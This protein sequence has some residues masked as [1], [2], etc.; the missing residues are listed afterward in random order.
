MLKYKKDAK[1]IEELIKACIGQV[2]IDDDLICK[3][4]VCVYPT[5][6][7]EHWVYPLSLRCSKRQ[8]G[9]VCYWPSSH[10]IKVNAFPNVPLTLE[11]G[12]KKLLEDYIQTRIIGNHLGIIYEQ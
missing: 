12:Y 1:K 2:G 9:S 7:D 8:I 3:V 5:C 6:K 11:K 10:K 4:G